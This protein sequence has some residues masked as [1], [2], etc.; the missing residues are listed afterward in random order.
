MPWESLE[1]EA[2][3]PCPNH[4]VG[5]ARSFLLPAVFT[6]GSIQN[7]RCFCWAQVQTGLEKKGSCTYF[8]GSSGKGQCVRRT[9]CLLFPLVY[10][11]LG[12]FL[13]TNDFSLMVILALLT[14]K[15]PA[16]FL[17]LT[18]LNVCLASF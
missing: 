5:C 7:S 9:T 8:L 16:C 6:D 18:H 1:T 11:V 13:K 2:A 15:F 17:P 3:F 10:D 12:I 4:A 14:L